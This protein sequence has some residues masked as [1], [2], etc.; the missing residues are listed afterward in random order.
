MKFY[1]NPRCSKSRAVQ[2]L[3]QDCEEEF[4]TIEYQK[5]PFTRADLVSILLKL[6]LKPAELIRKGDASKAGFD[7][8]KMSDDKILTT[9]AA[10]P[11]LVERPIVVKGNKAAL[12]RP[13]EDV[14]KIL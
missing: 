14:L 6:N 10:N 1:H 4:E 12:G 3:L 9:M 8:S 5:H 11:A 2:S 13:P 7:I